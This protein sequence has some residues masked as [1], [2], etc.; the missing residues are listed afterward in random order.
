MLKAVSCLLILAVSTWAS[1]LSNGR[2]HANMAPVPIVPIIAH[3]SSKPVTSS[4][5]TEL[6]PLNT[7][8]YFDQ[9]IDHN[10]P[11]LGTFKQR[12]W[13]TAQYYE[14]GGPIVLL[15]PG[16]DNAERKS[17][18][19]PMKHCFLLYLG[20][21]CSNLWLMITPTQ[22][23]YTFFLTNE[24]FNGQIA[25]QQNGAM[26]VLEHRYYGL[27]NPFNNLS[28]ASLQ[29]HTIQQA[30]DDLVYFANNVKLP[31]P[32]GGDVTPDKAPWVL[33]GGSYSGKSKQ[34]CF[35]NKI[36]V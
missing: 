6:P 14:T 28:T 9:L 34:E 19:M 25:Q 29:F 27:S 16:E 8:Y 4:N 23:V 3:D 21:S 36:G 2:S 12:F 13:H 24:T 5:G 17:P 18:Q 31:Q 7:T 35:L 10:N 1:R 22:I 26:I 30:I 33:V 20:L 32:D 15:T 11:S